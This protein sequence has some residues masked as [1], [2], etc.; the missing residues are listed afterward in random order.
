MKPPGTLVRR[1]DREYLL[2]EGG[3]S[4]DTRAI[5]LLARRDN[6]LFRPDE[7]Q[8]PV[9]WGRQG[10]WTPVARWTA[11]GLRVPISGHAEHT[12]LV[13]SLI[14]E[15]KAG[16][17]APPPLA[18]AARR[19]G[20]F[21][22]AL[23]AALPMGFAASVHATRAAAEAEDGA[24]E[25]VP[26]DNLAMFFTHLVREGYAGAIWNDQLPIFFC[27]DEH[28]DLQFLRV[29]PPEGDGTEPV[30]EILG[31]DN[32]F[33]LYDGEQKVDF[34]DNRDDCD[35]RL[36]AALGRVALVEWPETN[37]LWSLGPR[38]GEAAVLQPETEEGGEESVPHGV[39]FT[40][41]EAAEAFREET[42]PD[43]TLFPVNDV[44]AFLAQPPMAGCVAALNP[45]GH[46]AASGLLWHDGQRVVLDSFSGFWKYD[47]GDFEL[48]KE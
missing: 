8:P 46:R 27:V 12:A 47:R 14:D 32:R 21:A 15:Y 7:G 33:D 26:V 44:A 31:E 3:Y 18:F 29:S 40:S 25:I 24:D 19:D 9:A 1:D 20:G 43:L 42:A 2:I 16:R 23:H 48:L 37:R 6:P 17:P 13:Q 38:L 36:V 28:E 30:F 10:E 22:G 35:A 41:E 39:L 5:I 4:P 11:E 34:I 45:G